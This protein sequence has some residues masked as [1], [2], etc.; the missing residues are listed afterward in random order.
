MS[1]APCKHPAT[2]SWDDGV[3]RYCS[4]CGAE[5]GWLELQSQEWVGGPVPDSA[6]ETFEGW[7][8]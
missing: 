7:Q 3:T 1:D 4:S 2:D 6:V 5:T 8:R